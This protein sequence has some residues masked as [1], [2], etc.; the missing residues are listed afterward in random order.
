MPEILFALE[1][2][3]SMRVCGFESDYLISETILAQSSSSG[4]IIIIIITLLD[5]TCLAMNGA[6]Q[7]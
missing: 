4:I 1:L 6:H 7:S 2:H 5:S 3:H